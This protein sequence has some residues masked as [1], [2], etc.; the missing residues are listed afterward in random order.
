MCEGQPFV[1]GMIYSQ[2]M[3]IWKKQG[4]RMDFHVT[5]TNI[6]KWI[7]MV[8]HQKKIEGAK[9]NENALH[10][11]MCHSNEMA[12]TFYLSKD[13]REVAAR[14]TMI[15]AQCTQEATPPTLPLG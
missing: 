9:I 13:M 3:E 2:I 12:E 10:L 14:A 6:Q 11:D 5:A 15:I 8:C 7:V 4:V 1:G